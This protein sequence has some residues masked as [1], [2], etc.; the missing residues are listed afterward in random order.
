MR[1]RMPSR[2]C[3]RRRFLWMQL[4]WWNPKYQFRR[5]SLLGWMPRTQWNS[6]LELLQMRWRIRIKWRWISLRTR[7]RRSSP[8]SRRSTIINIEKIKK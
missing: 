8:K 1:W 4:R 5:I 7:R 2:K 3:F 6:F